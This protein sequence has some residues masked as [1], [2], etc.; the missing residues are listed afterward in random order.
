MTNAVN[1]TRVSFLLGLA[2]VLGRY[3]I[4]AQIPLH[5]AQQFPGR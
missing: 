4:E 1:T 3:L 5:V 2:F